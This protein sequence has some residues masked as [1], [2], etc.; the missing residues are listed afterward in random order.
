MIFIFA[1]HRYFW[2]KEEIMALVARSFPFLENPVE[3]FFYMQREIG[4]KIRQ[5]YENQE[6]RHC[7]NNIARKGYVI[8]CKY[9]SYI[10]FG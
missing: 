10:N 1:F 7:W 6:M 4:G 2:I 8:F 5:I 3:H 9:T